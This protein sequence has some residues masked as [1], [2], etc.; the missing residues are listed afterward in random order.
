MMIFNYLDKWMVIV[1][2]VHLLCCPFTK[3]EESFNLQAMHDLLYHRSNLSVVCNIINF[4]HALVTPF[5]Y[6]IRMQIFKIF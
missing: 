6:N 3:V 2:A 5:S 1:A 4:Y